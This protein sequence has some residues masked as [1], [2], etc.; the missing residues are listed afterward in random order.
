MFT[1][2]HTLYNYRLMF[3]MRQAADRSIFGDHNGDDKQDIAIYRSSNRSFFSCTKL[4]IIFLNAASL[5]SKKRSMIRQSATG[6]KL[7]T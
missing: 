2:S 1:P 3:D 4:K 6:R 7:L 5:A